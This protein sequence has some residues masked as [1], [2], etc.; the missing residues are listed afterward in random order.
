MC[1]LKSLVVS[2]SITHTCLL[3]MNNLFAYHIFSLWSMH[4]LVTGICLPYQSHHSG[5]TAIVFKKRLFHLTIV[6][7]RKSGHWKLEKPNTSHKCQSASFEYER[8]VIY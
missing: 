8:K 4:L 2:M 6:P 3:H 7:H 5:I 1:H